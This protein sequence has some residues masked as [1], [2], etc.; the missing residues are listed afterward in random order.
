MHKR[1]RMAV[2][3]CPDCEWEV[4]LGAQPKEGQRVTCPSCKAALE[5]VD[6]DPPEL[7]WAFDGFEPDWDPDDEEEWD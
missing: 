7:D 1:A 4:Y 5:V 2:A 6:L 3:S